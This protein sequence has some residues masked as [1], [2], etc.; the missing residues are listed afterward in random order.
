MQQVITNHIFCIC[1][2]L[3]KKWEYNEAVHQLLIDFKKAYDEF[4]RE[5]LFDI[6][7][8]FDISMKLVKLIKMCLN[9]SVAESGWA[10]MCMTCFLLA[11]F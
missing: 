1:Q 11:Q 10:R 9:E 7:I 6:L 3:Q 5:V 4:R 2:I 8:E